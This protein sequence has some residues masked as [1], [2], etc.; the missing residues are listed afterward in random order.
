[1][2]VDE[3]SIGEQILESYTKQDLQAIN[4]NYKTVFDLALEQ[5]ELHSKRPTKVVEPIVGAQFIY[6]VLTKLKEDGALRYFQH[7]EINSSFSRSIYQTIHTLRM[8]GY[9]SGT[10]SPTL[11]LTEEKGLDMLQILNT[12]E[13]LLHKHQHID[14]AELFRRA[15]HYGVKTSNSLYLLQSDLSLTYLEEQFL[16]K[17]LPEGSRKLPLQPVFGIQI[18][19]RTSLR[20]ISWGEPTP[21][22]YVYDQ[23][24]VKASRELSFFTAKTEEIELKHILGLIR[25]SE[26]KLDENVIFYTSGDPY[27]T[28][29]YHLAQKN[30]IPITFGEGI[31]ISVTRP[32][33][34]VKGFLQWVKANYSV[35]TFIDL[36]HGGVLKLGE[37]APSKTKI[38]R[39]LRDAQ[40]GW[41]KERYVSQ[42]NKKI[43]ALLVRKEKQDDEEK[44]TYYDE[45][46]QHHKWGVDWFK[47][48]MNKLPALEE[49]MND[50]ATLKAIHYMLVNHCKTTSALDEL[51]KASMLEEIGKLLPYADESYGQHQLFEKLEDLL[52]SLRVLRSNPK[53][54]HL[55]VT[56]YHKGLY[57]SRE[58]VYIVGLDNR[59]FPGS[60]NEDPL[61]LDEER[62]RLGHHLPFMQNS[63][64]ENLYTMLQ[65]FAQSIG[66]V[67]VSYCHFDVNENRVVSPAFVFLQCYR[68]A[69]GKKDAEFQDLKQLP[70]TLAPEE[71]VDERDY[72]SSKLV[73][74]KSANIDWKLVSH[75]DNLSFGNHADQARYVAAEFTEYDGLVDIDQEI[76]DPRKNKEKTLTAGKLESLAAC[77]YSY[78]IQE[79]LGVRPKEDMVYDPYSWLD[80]ATRGSLLH[81]IFEIYYREQ[82][83]TE[84][85]EDGEVFILQVAKDLI[86]QQKEVF[87][88]TNERVFQLEVADL[89]ACCRIFIKEEERHLES[90]EPA[91]FEYSFGLDGHEPAEIHLPSGESILLAGKIDR[92]DRKTDGK[93]HIIDYK[94]GSTYNYA[95]N[96]PFKGGRQLQHWI[97]ALAIEEHLKLE[98][99][100][101]EESAYYFP[102]VKGLGE[103]YTRKQDSVIRTNGF[104][105]LER[106]IDVISSGQFTMTDDPNDCK[107]CQLKTVCRRHFY[108][109]DHLKA[110][111]M[112]QNHEGLRRFK[113]VRAYD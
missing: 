87:P 104:D 103:R 1:M 75:F 50:K 38:T 99:G 23:E 107:F 56:S 34:F 81:R 96:D 111:Q 113:G 4:L 35:S 98:A 3:Y 30:D 72:W 59:K 64:Q 68:L 9:S 105:I 67:T 93:Y 5:E 24:H 27:Q 84:I 94:T 46:I 11:F 108:H 49:K 7:M 80:P 101:V 76:F 73:D 91:H 86:D 43:E 110:K 90:Y 70:S 53:P 42:L 29:L 13:K 82:K 37:G 97:Y 79:I 65:L 22:S 20:S 12:Y 18:P 74:S 71:L 48:R 112:D 102:T 47:I 16:R 88:P 55:H 63:G 57:H 58:N 69:T 100:I 40:I 15:S 41:S 17:L 26:T 51:A 83:E 10:L 28:H 6:R 8:A 36:L 32:G 106:L 89:L 19:E 2:I 61:L 45:L 66:S 62:K 44:R 39:M 77:P 60:S 14:Q 31:P 25:R 78:F 33:Q 21:L 52:L 92:V 54:G 85:K 109:D 95:M